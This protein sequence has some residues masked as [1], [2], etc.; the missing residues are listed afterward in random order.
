MSIDKNVGKNKEQQHSEGHGENRKSGQ[1]SGG[2]NNRSDKQR[3]IDLINAQLAKPNLTE[4]A[5][6]ALLDKKKELGG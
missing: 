5:R 1:S 3:Q 2:S 6:K 4:P